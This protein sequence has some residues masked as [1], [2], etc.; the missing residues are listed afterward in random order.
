M[1]KPSTGPNQ[2]PE[3]AQPV[4]APDPADEAIEVSIV[5]PCLNERDTIGECVRK[6]RQAIERESKAV[7]Q[8]EPTSR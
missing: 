6:A 4:A 1:M 8:G 2:P 7:G 3:V 5:M